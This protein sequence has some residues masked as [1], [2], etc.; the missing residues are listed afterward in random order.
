M[1]NDPWVGLYLLGVLFITGVVGLLL[2]TLLA[3][4]VSWIR[5]KLG[6]SK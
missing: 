2:R 6:G 5:E 4:A 1:P 3:C